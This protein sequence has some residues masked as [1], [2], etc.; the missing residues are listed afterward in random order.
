MRMMGSLQLRARYGR[1]IESVDRMVL[2]APADIELINPS[3]TLL[4]LVEVSGLEI[5]LADLL[6]IL[7]SKVDRSTVE[8]VVN[9]ERALHETA[10][11]T[12]SILRDEDTRMALQ[13]MLLQAVPR[14]PDGALDWPVIDRLVADY[15][16]VRVPCLIVWGRRDETLPVAM[17]YKLAAQ[18]PGAELHVLEECKHSAHLEFPQQCAEIIRRFE[19]VPAHGAEETTADSRRRTPVEAGTQG[20]Q[21]LALGTP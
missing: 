9:P 21:A 3:P 19:V 6:G 11:S 15:A 16:N 17:G 4:A 7:R 1:T 13:A 5:D 18:I 10:R 20:T 2:F 14:R 12:R 8:S